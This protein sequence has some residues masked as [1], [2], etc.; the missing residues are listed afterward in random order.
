MTASRNIKLPHLVVALVLSSNSL[1]AVHGADPVLAAASLKTI[2]AGVYDLNR[3]IVIPRQRIVPRESNKAETG[4]PAP[5]LAKQPSLPG[6]WLRGEDRFGTVLRF[7]PTVKGALIQTEDYGNS[8]AGNFW[9][10]ANTQG[11]TNLRANLCT[12]ASDFTVDGRAE[13]RPYPWAHPDWAPTPDLHGPDFPFRADGLCVQGSG[14]CL[15]RLR[16]YQIPG[17]ALRLKGGRGKQAGAYGIYD[18]LVGELNNIYVTLALS[19]IVV[20]AGDTKLHGIY[21]T[22]IVRDGLTM[23]GP[24]SVV[25]VDH[26]CGADRAVVVTQQT[27]FHT[28]YHE[29]ARIGTHILAEAPGTRIDGLNIGPATCWE[30]GVKIEA[31]GCTIKGLFGMVMGESAAHPDIAGVEILPRLINEV[32]EGALT[33]DGDGSEALILRGHRNKIDLKGGWNKRTNA[34]FVRVAE[35]IT[36]STVELRGVGDGGT[37]LDL[38]GSGLDRVDGQGNE[39]KIKWSGTA[40]RV[41]YPG[42][43]AVYNLARGTQLWID[44]RLQSAGEANPAK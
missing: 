6:G 44:G 9:N 16:F 28:A 27:E 35:A 41:I 25:D 14:F 20:E 5:Y 13:I 4:V 40:K 1:K 37:V 3:T 39:F 7:A 18:T 15:E 43:G 26:I 38:S 34:T 36:G 30:R 10:D 31:H 42:G 33:V 22:N 32:I 21:V 24:G 2:P 19:G 8:R 29:S 23:S 12:M 11:D 17:T